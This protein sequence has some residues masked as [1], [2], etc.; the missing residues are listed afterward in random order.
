[1]QRT[2]GDRNVRRS[3]G[4]GGI[5]RA[6]E[7]LSGVGVSKVSALQSGCRRNVK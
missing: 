7:G 3:G 6:G 5:S 2:S 1:M 4:Q